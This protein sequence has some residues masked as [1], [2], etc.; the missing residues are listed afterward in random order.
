MA[1]IALYTF[2]DKMHIQHPSNQLSQFVDDIKHYCEGDDDMLEH[3][4]LPAFGKFVRLI[5]SSN[6]F[7]SKKSTILGTETLSAAGKHAKRESYQGAHN[8]AH[9]GRIH[10]FQNRVPPRKS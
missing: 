8:L 2:L 9:L 10:F 1:R 7:I 4:F 3:L 6:F 5:K